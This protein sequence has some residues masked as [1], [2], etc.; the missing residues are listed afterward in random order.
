MQ[1]E[2]LVSVEDAGYTDVSNHGLTLELNEFNGVKAP[3]RRG[4]FCLFGS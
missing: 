2:F 3:E 4:D 1:L